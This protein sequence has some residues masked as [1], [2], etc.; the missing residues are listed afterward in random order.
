MARPA[1][2]ERASVDASAMSFDWLRV[3]AP[4]MIFIGTQI[5]HSRYIFAGRSLYSG[6]CRWPRQ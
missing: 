5:L 3:I 6:I 1:A 4:V 2:E